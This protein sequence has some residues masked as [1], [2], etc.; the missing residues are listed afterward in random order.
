MSS[1]DQQQ[2]GNEMLNEKEFENSRVENLPDNIEESLSMLRNIQITLNKENHLNVARILSLELDNKSSIRVKYEIDGDSLEIFLQK[3]RSC[4]RENQI[5]HIFSQ[6][7]QGYLHLKKLNII[8]NNLN[9]Q[10]IFIKQI[11]RTNNFLVKVQIQQQNQISNYSQVIINDLAEK[12]I[13]QNAENKN[14]TFYHNEKNQIYFLGIILEQLCFGT[15]SQN[16]SGLN[17]SVQSQDQQLPSK[18]QQLIQQ[19]IVDD[20][21][22]R[23]SWNELIIH[24]DLQLTY[25]LLHQR[26]FIDLNVVKNE[27]YFCTFDLKNE[28]LNLLTKRI[29]TN[30]HQNEI[31][32]VRQMKSK[33]SLQNIIEYIEIIE[34]YPF[35]YFIME[36]WEFNLYEYINDRQFQLTLAEILQFLQQILKA[37]LEV[38]A[39]N[40][41]KV[42]LNP[43]NITV[44]W[45]QNN[46]ILFKIL[47]IGQLKQFTLG[48]KS[49]ID[50][51]HYD[52][53]EIILGSTQNQQSDIFS[54]GA[55]LHYITYGKNV[56]PSELQNFQDLKEYLKTIQQNGFV[57]QK[58]FKYFNDFYLQL[59]D[60]ML[61]YS[62]QSR[63]DWDN[64]AKKVI[65]V[66]QKS[67]IIY[68]QINY[69]Q[70][71]Q[72]EKEHFRK[73]SKILK[74]PLKKSDKLKYIDQLLDL[75]PYN[76]SLYYQKGI[77]KLFLGQ[78]LYGMRDLLQSI[79]CFDQAIQINPKNE[80]A[81]RMK[82]HL[83]F[84]LGRG[85]DQIKCIED[86]IRNNPKFD[87]YN[88]KALSLLQM[89]KVDELIECCDQI[90]Q[91]DLKDYLGYEV[92]ALFLQRLT[93]YDEAIKYYKL[94]FSLQPHSCDLI[95]IAECLHHLGKNDEANTH[96][97][98][99]I[100]QKSDESYYY[101]SKAK[102]LSQLGKLDEAINILDLGIKTNPK[103]PIFYSIKVQ[104]KD[105][106]RQ[107]D[108][109][110]CL[111]QGIQ[112]NPGN[113]KFLLQNAQFVKQ[114]YKYQ[115]AIKYLDQA[116]LLNPKDVNNYYEKSICL[117][118]LNLNDD[119]LICFNWAI[120]FNPH[121]D[122]LFMK[123][124]ELLKD[125][126]RYDEAIL[127][128][129][130]ALQINPT[131]FY[132]YILKGQCLQFLGNYEEALNIFTFALQLDPNST[133]CYG[134]KGNCLMELKK[135]EEA[136][137]QFKEAISIYNDNSNDFYRIAKCLQYLRNYDEAINYFNQ[138]IQLNPMEHYYY[139]EKCLKFDNIQ[140]KIV[141]K[142]RRKMRKQ[143]FEKK[144]DQHLVF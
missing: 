34:E 32:F 112:Y 56:Y 27:E 75:H 42:K 26:Y 25:L 135:Y 92:K 29:D 136:I 81:Y 66:L 111:E 61:K 83:L 74:Q 51:L 139:F 125:I 137:K 101:Q 79:E 46:Q 96:Y 50:M 114:I 7:V 129:N 93:L 99:A 143:N 6:I 45:N 106:G 80:S 86:L 141:Q 72:E 110:N 131:L 78:L 82:S 55:I 76:K 70:M 22:K 39:L 126:R 127:C 132:C 103:D 144:S 108:V 138:A 95:N 133:C 40:I 23:I 31:E 120:Q 121:D 21:Q 53:P 9:I 47:L 142:N 117:Q 1:R 124:G 49:H 134:Y 63:I 28:Y 85:E 3:R 102:F 77:G 116:I 119:A 130:T 48:D 122:K 65:I 41:V 38:Q 16:Q 107:D 88:L 100:Q 58:P 44:K 12:S 128:L 59:I 109:I 52:A 8:Y 94:K 73:I 4:L 18:L 69:V 64:L 37:Y 20:D 15:K 35:T 14:Q 71:N 11:H 33:G 140:Q 98:Q 97:D 89:G 13:Q 115:E 57:C 60:E 123:K 90:I 62:S 43:Q 113:I 84:T 10:N 67:H 36:N 30:L 104:L 24:Q 91:L 87:N 2:K 68:G 17:K 54:L 105:I 118:A 19:M 5:T